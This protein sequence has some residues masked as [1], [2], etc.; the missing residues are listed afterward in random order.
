MKFIKKK[1]LKI[2]ISSLDKYNNG[3]LF[4]EILKVSTEMDGVTVLKGITSIGSRHIEHRFN[5][6]SV[7]QDLPIIIE[8][9]DNETNIKDFLNKNSD[10]L[11][12]SFITLSDVEVIEN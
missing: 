5:I 11:K 7:S 3:I 8:I 9:I 1:S 4:E 10:M 6:L 2:Y 12:D